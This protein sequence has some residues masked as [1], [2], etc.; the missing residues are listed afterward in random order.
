MYQNGKEHSLQGFKSM[1][2]NPYAKDPDFTGNYYTFSWGSNNDI[3]FFVLDCRWYRD[4]ANGIQFGTQQIEW[5][6]EQLLQS[7]ATFKVIVTGMDVMERGMSSEVTVQLGEF[8]SKHSISGV[9]FHSG[10]IHRNELKIH[11]YSDTWPYP[12]MQITSSGI[13]MVWRRP[14][15]IIDVDTTNDDDPTLTVSFYGAKDKSITTE[16]INDPDLEC[17]SI[18]GKDRG[19]EHTCTE[20]IHLSQLSP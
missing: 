9:I 15:A 16:W 14:F 7:K 12:V 3:Q 17:T 13:G 6:F 4:D 18:E 1:W 19:K 10:D 20:T 8:V 2:G 11:T 5:L